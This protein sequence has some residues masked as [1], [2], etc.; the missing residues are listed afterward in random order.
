MES[1]R[2]AR[3]AVG[4]GR[5][6]LDDEACGANALAGER[7]LRRVDDELAT[8]I[9]YL[10]GVIARQRAGRTNASRAAVAGHGTAAKRGL[11][12]TKTFV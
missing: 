4:R 3:A 8:L 11:T 12:D 5:P 10:P 2:D 6:V 1:A 9:E 7:H